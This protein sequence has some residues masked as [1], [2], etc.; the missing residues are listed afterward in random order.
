M[1]QTLYEWCPY[2][3]TEIHVLWDIELQGYL[4]KC[5]SCGHNLLLCGECKNNCDYDHRT[6]LCQHL[7]ESIWEDLTDIPMEVPKKDEEYIADSVTL[8]GITFPSGITRTELWHWFDEHHPK[9]IAYLLYNFK[10]NQ[11]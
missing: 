8:H 3:E 2:C 5:P 4:T 10:N 1:K 11:E 7:V 6:D 9:G